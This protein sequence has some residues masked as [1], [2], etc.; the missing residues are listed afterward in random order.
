M[1]TG[2]IRTIGVAEYVLRLRDE[3]T[4][5]VQGIAAGIQGSMAPAMLAVADMAG[6]MGDK[7]MAGIDQATDAAMDFETAFTGVRKTID[8]SEAEYSALSD[9]IRQLALEIPVAASELANIAAAAGQLGIQKE[10]I[11]SFTRVIADLGVSSNLAGEEAAQ[12]LARFANITQMPQ[13]QFSNLGSAIVDLGN[14][15][16]T[17]EAEIAAMAL[18]LAGAGSQIGLTEGE[19]LGFATALS[20]VGIEAEAGGSAISTLMIK[21]AQALSEGGAKFETFAAV[22]GMSA[23]QFASKWQSEPAMALDAFIRGLDGVKQSG[24]DVFATLEALEITEI[25][26]RDAV[27][28]LAGARDLLGNAIRTGNEAFAENNALSIEA[29]KQY[30][31][32]ANQLQ[33]L[34]NNWNEI[35]ILLG[36]ALLPVI[37]EMV[38]QII[39]LVKSL[40]EWIKTN[41]DLTATIM[42]TAVG[43]GLLGQ[44]LGF[45]SDIIMPILGIFAT[46]TLATGGLGVA[47][48]GAAA[49]LLSMVAGFIALTASGLAFVA[50]VA[51]ITAGI[52]SIGVSMATTVG[53][54]MRLGESNDRLSASMERYM[55]RLEAK[56][57]AIDRD[58]VR[59]MEHGE[60]MAYL[61]EQEAMTSDNLT[62]IYISNIT[63]KLATEEEFARAKNLMLNENIS[64][65]EAAALA[66]MN[67][68]DSL[69]M[70]LLQADQE[71]TNAYLEE[72]GVRVDGTAVGYDAIRNLSTDIAQQQIQANA[73]ATAQIVADQQASVGIIGSIWQA[74]IDGI[75]WAWNNLVGMVMGAMDFVGNNTS[76]PGM[77]TG[78]MISGSGLVNVH[79]DELLLLPRG[80]E[81]VPKQHSDAVRAAMGGGGGNVTI[82]INNPTVR[83]DADIRAITR[84]VSNAIASAS[85]SRMR[86]V[87]LQP[88]LG[89]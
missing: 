39:E 81:V 87:G 74:M 82:H 6:A 63:G 15:F 37:R 47:S 62:K 3:M 48:T 16:A 32:T 52:L 14:N 26:Q 10:N 78:G 54:Y 38:P 9:S 31:T 66:S 70:E 58:K 17:T 20:S 28:R 24:G 45:L 64:R 50:G 60:A 34:T 71:L 80:A 7:I 72:M 51:A 44:S 53:E 41:P 33:M 57:A 23:D 86:N 46:Y 11:I 19:I 42:G 68:A 8:A 35:K 13:E 56:G 67:L 79:K 65:E 77:A 83:S 49:G 36:E 59:S 75:A 89:A 22:A 55:D 43:V 21:I 27:L 73:E 84:Q 25:R 69:Y 12:M 85:V 88:H 5:S 30:A 61:A 18:R 40:A 1:G 4:A 76:I 29:E 2:G